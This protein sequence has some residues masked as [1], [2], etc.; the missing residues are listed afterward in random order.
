MH[1]RTLLAAAVTLAATQARAEADT[2]RLSHGLGVLYLPLIVMREAKLLEAELARANIRATVQWAVLDGAGPIN[3]ALI[4]GAL[5]IAGNSIPGFLTI[6]SRA[7]GGRSEVVGV[8][9]LSTAAM[10]LNTNRPDIPHARGLQA[11][12]QDRRAQRQGQHPGRGAA[13]GRCQAVRGRRVRAPGHQHRQPLPPHRRHGP[14]V[15]QQGPGRPFR[16]PALHRRR[17]GQPQRARRAPQ[18]GRAGATSRSTWCSPPSASPA[19]TRATSAPFSPPSARANFIIKDDPAKAIELF[20]RNSGSKIDPTALE[21]VLAEPDTKFDT[22]PPRLHALRRVHAARRHHQGGAE[23]LARGVRP[24]AGG[25]GGA[26]PLPH[27][28]PNRRQERVRLVR[29]QPVAGV[30]QGREPH[31]RE[32]LAEDRP[33]LRAAR[34]RTAPPAAPARGRR[35]G[36]RP[37]IP[38]SAAT[39]PRSPRG[40]CATPAP[41]QSEGSAAGTPAGPGPPPRARAPT[42]PPPA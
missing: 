22:A 13:D 33:V 42:T 26:R 15:R 14:A 4:A 23:G 25:F 32:Q 9:G 17:G 37:A 21:A 35:S 10:I 11:R 39:R 31:R 7:R 18:P 40:R 34:S 27:E 19:P 20:V 6:W 30:P 12:R 3:D 5:D 16:E 38:R 41:P 29:V 1:R 8:S 2:V 28:R 24:G 36:R